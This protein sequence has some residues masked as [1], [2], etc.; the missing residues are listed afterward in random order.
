MANQRSRAQARPQ[1]MPEM[2]F[3]GVEQRPFS[4]TPRRDA[5][6]GRRGRRLHGGERP[7]RKMPK[8]LRSTH[9]NRCAGHQEDGHHGSREP[10]RSWRPNAKPGV[11]R[12]AGGASRRN[13]MARA[14]FSEPA[15]RIE[16]RR[17]GS[18]AMPAPFVCAG[19]AVPGCPNRRSIAARPPEWHARACNPHPSVRSAPRA[20]RTLPRVADTRSVR[21]RSAGHTG[22]PRNRRNRVRATPWAG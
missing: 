19:C 7:R 3:Q 1:G 11:A 8:A 15:E 20:N 16:V 2:R 14:G 4:G 9:L 13:R 12:G 10:A 18:A 17:Q 5:G 22:L 21:P 6:V